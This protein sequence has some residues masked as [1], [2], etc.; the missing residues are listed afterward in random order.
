LNQPTGDIGRVQLDGSATW[1]S[2]GD[3]V[4]GD[5][6]V[7]ADPAGAFSSAERRP[8]APA[9]LVPSFTTLQYL[10]LDELNQLA[11]RGAVNLGE[12]LVAISVFR[13]SDYNPVLLF[14]LALF[15]ATGIISS[16]DV[17]VVANPANLQAADTFQNACGWLGV[18]GQT[19]KD[20][21]L[22][23]KRLAV[24]IQ[25]VFLYG[26]GKPTPAWLNEQHIS[27]VKRALGTTVPPLDRA[28]RGKLATI[29]GVLNFGAFVSQASRYISAMIPELPRGRCLMSTVSEMA[30]AKLVGFGDLPLE[31][32]KRLRER[33]ERLVR[34]DCTTLATFYKAFLECD[35]IPYWVGSQ[36]HY[37]VFKSAYSA[38]KLH[39]WTSFVYYAP[40]SGDGQVI[41]APPLGDLLGLQLSE[42]LLQDA[43]A[44]FAQAIRDLATMPIY[45]HCRNMVNHELVRLCKPD[46]E[47]IDSQDLGQKAV[48]VSRLSAIRDEVE[49]EY[50]QNE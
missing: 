9:A 45:K 38:I 33:M 18:E 36:E 14:T 46:Q 47:R 1:V 39:G 13:T 16:F 41:P 44:T 10:T 17:V 20:R 15:F 26:V 28:T 4:D 21:L 30:P 12:I 2:A 48:E 3:P 6:Y 40:R 31:L 35:G 22:A 5:G 24:F 50:L 42:K 23:V 34:P 11:D 25:V 49:E 19:D 8:Q 7:F 27:W 43:A 29:A 32:T 37:V